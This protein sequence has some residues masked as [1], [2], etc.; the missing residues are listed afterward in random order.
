MRELCKANAVKKSR[1]MATSGDFSENIYFVIAHEY[2][3]PYML[4]IVKTFRQKILMIAAPKPSES[5]FIAVILFYFSFRGGG[6]ENERSN[7]NTH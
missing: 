6:V 2:N 5:K 1:R 3:I 7:S 4:R